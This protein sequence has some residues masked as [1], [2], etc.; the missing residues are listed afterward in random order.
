VSADYV[1]SKILSWTKNSREARYIVTLDALS[2]LRAKRDESFRKCVAG[3]D[4]T[5]P[6]GKGLTMALRF[7]GK[8]VQQRIAGVDLVE[9]MCRLASYERI[10]VYFYG[11]RQ[12][13]ADEAASRMA[14]RF[15]GLRV[16]GT[17][18]GYQDEE[19]RVRV[20]E[21]IRSS[22]ARFVFVAL[23]VP[24]Q[25]SWMRQNVPELERAVCIG[26]G[27]SLD[28]LS[29]RLK[30]APE[31][32]QKTGCEWLYRLIQEPWRW[33]RVAGLPVFAF[34]VMLTKTGLYRNRGMP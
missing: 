5:L 17:A 23:G 24:K 29:G 31:V 34:W 15:P 11:G 26:V 9:K 12:G 16:A 22:G 30:R 7:L 21:D 8:P 14:A 3:A 28:I 20:L 4:L 10:P 1:L 19:G 25:E 32:W 13:V 27:G 33:R 18:H 6:D 2:T